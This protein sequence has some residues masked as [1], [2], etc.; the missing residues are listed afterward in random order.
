MK[1]FN[2]FFLLIII[3]L[4]VVSANAQLKLPG[5][6]PPKWVTNLEHFVDV[7]TPIASS[8]GTY[9][10]IGMAYYTGRPDISIP[11][12][13]LKVRGFSMP[14]TLSYDASGV[15][16]NS[17]PTWVGQNW[18]LNV[19]GVITRNRCWNFDEWVGSTHAR[20]GSYGLTFNYFQCH[21][22]LSKS[23]CKNRVCF[24]ME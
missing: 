1:Q 3:N 19:G 23:K 12:Y 4:F 24:S 20:N 11:L 10:N 15:M 17:L 21:G 9:G 14:I 22:V 13:N 8:L 2:K 18:T 5:E 7:P 6:V 16:P